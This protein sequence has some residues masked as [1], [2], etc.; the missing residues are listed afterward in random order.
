MIAVGRDKRRLSSE[1]DPPRF[2]GRRSRAWV[3]TWAIVSRSSANEMSLLSLHSSTSDVYQGPPAYELNMASD[4]NNTLAFA[5]WTMAYAGIGSLGVS[6]WSSYY[7]NVGRVLLVPGQL[8]VS[9]HACRRGHRGRLGRRVDARRLVHHPAPPRSSAARHEPQAGRCH[10]PC[11][12]KP[13]KM[14][15]YYVF[16]WGLRARGSRLVAGQRCKSPV[17]V[18]SSR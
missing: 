10:Q 9:F 2:R 3:V 15:S 4:G 17:A 12:V 16:A 14:L 7:H 8:R 13:I 18:R 1:P 11:G 6:C 5:R